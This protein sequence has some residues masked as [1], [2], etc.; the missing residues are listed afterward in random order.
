MVPV[1][2]GGVSSAPHR[3]E[4]RLAKGDLIYV[5]LIRSIVKEVSCANRR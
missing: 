3:S 1:V 5:R 4:V 2:G